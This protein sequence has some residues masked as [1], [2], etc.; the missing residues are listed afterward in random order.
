MNIKRLAAKRDSIIKK[1]IKKL[2]ATFN[3]ESELFHLI[4]AGK[5]PAQALPNTLKTFFEKHNFDRTK[6]TKF[7]MRLIANDVQKI[8]EEYRKALTHLIEKTYKLPGVRVP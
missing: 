3:N 4:V 2:A 8:S 1:V 6:I 7:L 5:I